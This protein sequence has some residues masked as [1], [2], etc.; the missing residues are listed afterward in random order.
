[1]RTANI[2]K[3]KNLA[4]EL[5]EECKQYDFGLQ[6]SICSS[7]DSKLAIEK[8]QENRP[9]KWLDLFKNMFPIQQQ[10][11]QMNGCLNLTLCFR[12]C[13]TG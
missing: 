9:A 10:L 4:L 3:T 1:M 5:R 8:Y 12:L 11:T 2:N 6:D 13:S 7:E